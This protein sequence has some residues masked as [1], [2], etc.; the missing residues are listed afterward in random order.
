ML[1]IL[2][3]L[4]CFSGTAQ[5]FERHQLDSGIMGISFGSEN[6]LKY[7]GNIF[8]PT[9]PSSNLFNW[10]G[11]D[12]LISL[13]YFKSKNTTI[14][15]KVSL[16]FRSKK[17]DEIVEAF[18]DQLNL[19]PGKVVRNIFINESFKIGLG[20]GSEKNYGYKRWRYYHGYEG[21][22]SF[23]TSRNRIINGNPLPLYLGAIL[24]DR[25][26]VEFDI[27]A[28]LLAGFE[29]M[30]LPHMSLG[31]ELN[32]GAYLTKSTAGDF[33]IVE[34]NIE[35]DIVEVFKKGDKKATTFLL[36]NVPS[37]SIKANIYFP[38]N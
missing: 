18:D 24:D 23:S 30:L 22:F 10:E 7:I 17:T 38:L 31:I 32:W 15:L 8:T 28:L 34:E 16:R 4:Y 9:S 26:G 13:K 14:R 1:I 29:Y 35:G 12:S 36:D 2:W 20:I 6:L 37:P 19:I 25:S 33:I 11:P 5:N 3:S 21:F 27:R